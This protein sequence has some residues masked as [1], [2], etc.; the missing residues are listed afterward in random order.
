MAHCLLL[1][2]FYCYLL[3]F[4]FSFCGWERGG[5]G[6]WVASYFVICVYLLTLQFH[7]M[8]VAS[9]EISPLRLTT[10]LLE[11][12]ISEVTHK[13]LSTGPRM[14]CLLVK[15]TPWLLEKRRLKIKAIMNVLLKMIMAKQNLPSGSMSQVNPKL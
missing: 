12:V 5:G 3:L 9:L 4:F 11:S 1:L 6:G 10:H 14:E 15:T 8:F 7:P 13:Y 2:L